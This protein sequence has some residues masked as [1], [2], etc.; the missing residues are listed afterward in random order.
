VFSGAVV[1]VIG[2]VGVT[3]LHPQGSG[4][5]KLPSTLEVAPSSSED[6]S[7]VVCKDG[8]TLCTIPTNTMLE[9]HS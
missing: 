6:S 7:R 4:D 2:S 9:S 5:P 3:T 1:A 8:D